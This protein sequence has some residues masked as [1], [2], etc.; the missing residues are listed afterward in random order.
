M[1]LITAVP[2]HSRG[3]ITIHIPTHS[4]SSTSFTFTFSR[5]IFSIAVESF[6]SHSSPKPHFPTYLF[7]FLPVPISVANI[8]YIKNTK[9]PIYSIMHS[10]QKSPSYTSNSVIIIILTV[11]SQQSV[12][13]VSILCSLCLWSWTFLSRRVI[14]TP[15]RRMSTCR[16]VHL[17]RYVLLL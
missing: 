17:Y 15:V 5:H 2:S 11:I 16:W 1:I 7:L 10:Q 12:I 9:K 8:N 3:I 14:R 4:Y 13:I 6:P